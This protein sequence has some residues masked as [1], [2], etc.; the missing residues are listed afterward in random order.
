MKAQIF[1][2]FKLSCFKSSLDKMK[3]ENIFLQSE[4]SNEIISKYKQ[5]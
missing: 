1:G 4:Q 5:D 3:F 2:I